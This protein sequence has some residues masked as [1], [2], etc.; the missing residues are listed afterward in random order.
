[1]TFLDPITWLTTL[2]SCLKELKQSDNLTPVFEEVKLY[3]STQMEE[4]LRDL[5]LRKNR[6]CLVVPQEDSFDNKLEG[7]TVVSDAGYRVSLL[8]ADRDYRSG[9]RAAF[10]D[11]ESPGTIGMKH[12]VLKA[13]VGQSLGLPFVVMHPIEGDTILVS[14]KGQ[15]T[16]TRKAYLLTFQTPAGR[17]QTTVRRG[18]LNRT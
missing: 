13:L 10:G 3:D 18:T 11:S 14:N 17:I 8:I 15:E 4:A 2:V 16:K 12:L 6:L 1:M 9:Q 7:R 5:T